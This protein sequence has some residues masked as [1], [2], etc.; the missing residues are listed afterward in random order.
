MYVRRYIVRSSNSI[1]VPIISLTPTVRGGGLHPPQ[2][3]RAFRVCVEMEQKRYKILQN[4]QSPRHRAL[5]Q[6]V[7]TNTD[8]FGMERCL[9]T[10]VFTIT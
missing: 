2:Y 9:N 5:K 7:I 3:K 1:Y 10:R 8:S 6:R 4:A